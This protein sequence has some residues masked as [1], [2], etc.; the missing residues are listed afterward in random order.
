MDLVS[1]LILPQDKEALDE[2]DISLSDER[3][4]K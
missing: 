2:C 4:D 3:N 1:F